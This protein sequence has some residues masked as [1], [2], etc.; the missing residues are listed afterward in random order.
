VE[1]L[2]KEGVAVG[3]EGE[4]ADGSMASLIV[5]RDNLESLRRAAGGGLVPRRTTFLSPFDSLFWARGRDEDLWGFRQVLEAYKPAKDRIWGYFSL[6]ILHH[7]RLV[8][9]FDPKLDRK[10][11][12][13]RLEA[14][15]LEP[16]IAVE[17]GMVGDVAQA[18]G[19]FMQF[20]EATELVVEQ[21]T[22]TAFGAQLLKAL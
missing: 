7:D 19:D 21:S 6:P 15:M 3:V 18:M 20:H 16:G 4:L 5:H 13:L 10:T 8:G 22:P 12:T 17:E 9:R 1:Q 2:I 11:G 14:L